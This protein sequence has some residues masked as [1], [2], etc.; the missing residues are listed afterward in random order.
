[1]KL[2]L[3]QDN[4]VGYITKVRGRG[5]FRKRITEMGFVKGKKVIVV[6]NAPLKDPVEY[7]IMGYEVSLRRSEASLIEVIT[8]EEARKLEINKYNGVISEAALKTSARKKGKEIQV[9]LVGNP[10]SGKTSLFNFASRSKEH[11]GNYSGVTVDSKTAE[12]KVRDYILNITDLPGTYSLSAYSPEELY[13]RKYIFGEIPDIIVN[14]VDASNLE[15]N[16]YLTTQLID[17]DIKV[18]IALNMY[19]ELRKKG[20]EFDFDSLGKMIG[21]PIIPTI[22]SK[23]FGIKDLFDKVIQVYEDK[24]PSVRH[25]HI[26]YGKDV[27]KSIRKIQDVIWE[28]KKLTDIV[29]SRFYAI[30][31]LEKDASANFTLSKWGNYKTI[32]NTAEKEIKSL[33]SLISEDSETIITDAKY[34]FIAGA[35]KETYKG[36]IN[37]R[38]KKT[39]KID[40]FLTHKYFGF[41]FFIFFLW[42]MFQ[43]TFTL[44][45]YPMEWIDYLVTLL[46]Q[47]VGN[48]MSNGPLKDLL[49]NG[50]I[51]GVG[52]VIIFL[53]NILILFFFISLMED[54]GY[55]ARAAFIMDRIMHKIGLHG[56]SFIPLIMGFGCNV[57]AIMATRTIE[58]RQ[59]RILTMLINPFM[60]CSARLPVYV[61]II[62][63]FFTERPGLVLF[64]IYI[65]GVAVAALMAILFKKT[66]FRSNET[67]FVMELPP[68]R[69]PTLR[70]LTRHMWFKGVQYIN[71]MGGVI[72]VASIIIWALGYYP[73]EVSYSIDFD[74]AIAQ[75]K[76]EN[77]PDKD[78][79]TEDLLI[80]KNAEKQ[81]KSYIGRIGKSIEPIM[82]PL[83][84]DW[85]MSVSL[86]S[87]VAAKEIVVSTMGVLYQAEDE[88]NNNLINRLQNE[89]DE[90]GNQRFTPLVAY[91]F[92]IFILLYFPCVASIAAISKE[93]GHWKW[94]VF[95]MLYTTFLA[96]FVSLLIHQIGSLII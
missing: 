47:L 30:K 32:K 27:E 19:D 16:L 10:N 88:G 31:L 13:V 2:S 17:M 92:L 93:S 22:G 42:L 95:T 38:R 40:N 87:G 55:M 84:F 5:A 60:S 28:N 4:E 44:G 59:N 70:N 64:S 83:G 96:W 14:V 8:K 62:S 25:I 54:T 67:P 34:G 20:D 74:Q 46:G 78:K 11:V 53:P 57:P 65:I 52:G 69:I 71:K 37:T 50:V 94:A 12:C 91:G 36:N 85:K 51:G 58:N 61:L 81:A 1:M 68:Y 90:N 3:L 21:I 76:I 9:A 45:Q 18:V 80:A 56:R 72:L 66:I 43:S 23:G 15:R 26:N 73:K 63:A 29:S 79:I 49:I 41:P 86:L 24:D 35:L 6:K 39:E 7:S 82:R 89:K 75:A 48:I 33:E 77:S